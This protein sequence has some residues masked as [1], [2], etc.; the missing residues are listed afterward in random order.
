MDTGR[1]LEGGN[2]TFSGLKKSVKDVECT[3]TVDAHGIGEHLDRLNR[4]LR[5]EEAS[6]IRTVAYPFNAHFMDD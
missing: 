5:E 2:D 3:V 4:K 1:R 6:I